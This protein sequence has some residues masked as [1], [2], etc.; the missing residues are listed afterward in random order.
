MTIV[1][2]SFNIGV[3]YSVLF[4]NTCVTTIIINNGKIKAFVCLDL[5][6]YRLICKLC[7][8]TL[9]MLKLIAKV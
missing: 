4:T 6:I 5:N 1:H 3:T 8:C 9:I 7:I 2:T